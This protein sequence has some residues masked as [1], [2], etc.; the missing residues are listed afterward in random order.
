MNAKQTGII[1]IALFIAMWSYVLDSLLVGQSA[2]DLIGGM[3]IL[4][5]YIVVKTDSFTKAGEGIAGFA[6]K[7]S[8]VIKGTIKAK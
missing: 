8:R 2:Y 1:D 5:A 3:A 4:L 7:L 6:K